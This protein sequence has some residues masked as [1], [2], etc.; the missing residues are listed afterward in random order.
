[1][2]KRVRGRPISQMAWSALIKSFVVHK[3]SEG[4][5]LLCESMLY[6]LQQ[7]PSLQKSRLTKWTLCE[8]LP[9]PMGF[10]EFNLDRCS[11]CNLG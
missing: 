8:R 3:L 5:G 1:M 9:F 11:L 7:E 4:F 2:L 6:A 10:A